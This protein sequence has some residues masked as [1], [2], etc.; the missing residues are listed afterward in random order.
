VG[1]VAAAREDF[2]A[3]VA[4]LERAEATPALDGWL[5]SLI[6]TRIG[7]FD[8]QAIERQLR[9]EDGGGIKAVVEVAPSARGA[10]PN[11]VPPEG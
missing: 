8:L 1:S 4:L 6:T 9:G 2:E 3:A 11:Y 10:G 7:G 5:G